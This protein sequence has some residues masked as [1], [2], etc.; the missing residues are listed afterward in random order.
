MYTHTGSYRRKRGQHFLASTKQCS[1]FFSFHVVCTAHSHPYNNKRKPYRYLY[2]YITFFDSFK[3]K[4]N[5]V[6]RRK[7]QLSTLNF[8]FLKVELEIYDSNGL[9]ED[10]LPYMAK[11]PPGQPRRVPLVRHFS[12]VFLLF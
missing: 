7:C 2:I 11:G 6:T 10:A 3:K 9:K 12:S 1:S 8:F 5:L 4:R